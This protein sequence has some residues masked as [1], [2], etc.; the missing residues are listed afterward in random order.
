MHASCVSHDMRAPLSAISFMINRILNIPRIPRKIVKLLKPVLCASKIL[1]SQVN[2][3]L[4]YNLLQQ[5]QFK[6]NPSRVNINEV[7]E[8]ITEALRPQ[9]QMNRVEII[10][11][12][13]QE[14]P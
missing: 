11:D 14:V 12:V 8:E 3:L 6:I 13:D 10:V 4:D 7:I 9:A 5:N 1:N 2:N